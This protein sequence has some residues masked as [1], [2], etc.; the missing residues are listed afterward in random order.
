[1]II[2]GDRLRIDYTGTSEQLPRAVNVVPIY[3]FAYTAYGAKVV[4]CPDV[5]NNEGSFAPITTWAPE[6]S[7]LNPRFPA[8]GGARNMIG[9]LLPVAFMGAIAH[10]VPDRVWAPGASN[11]SMTMAGEHDGRRYAGLYFFN[12]GQGAS[13]KRSG[14]SALSFPSNLS[15]TPIE[16]MEKAMPIRVLHRRLRSGS[17]GVGARHGGEG[18]EFAF[19]FVGESCAVSSFILTRFKVPPPGLVGGGPGLRA[20]LVIN[21]REVDP[22]EHVLLNKGDQVLIETAG[23]GGFGAPAN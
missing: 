22:T 19:E 6:G 4:L 2:D 16:L 15:N 9:H 10:L 8:P 3:T 14:L 7:I 17:G 1:V 5:P 21:H 20:R 18:L 11:S 23:G 13:H 12:G